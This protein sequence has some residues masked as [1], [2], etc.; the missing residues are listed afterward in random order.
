MIE[1]EQLDEDEQ[2]ALLRR[3][4]VMAESLVDELGAEGL[5]SAID[6]AR[7]LRGYSERLCVAVGETTFAAAVEA[8]EKWAAE[9]GDGVSTS[10]TLAYRAG[11]RI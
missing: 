8:V 11:E 9:R 7:R 2:Q 4:L 5:R 6:R 3:V 1:D 10:E